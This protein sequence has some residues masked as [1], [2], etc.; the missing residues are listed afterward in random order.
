MKRHLKI[1]LVLLVVLLLVHVA[2]FFAQGTPGH[3]NIDEGIYQLQ[4]EAVAAG[5]GHAIDNGYEIFP[6]PE[7]Q[8]GNQRHTFVQDYGGRLVGQYPA[9]YG[10]LIAPLYGLLGFRA[11]VL[12]N[13]LAFPILVLLTWHIGSL[14]FDH[15]TAGWASLLLVGGTYTWGYALA[16]WPHVL[17]A[18]LQLLSV[19]LCIHAT[20]AE[21]RRDSILLALSGGLA[22]GLAMGVRYDALF[23][24]VPSLIV[25]T[26]RGR[27]RLVTAVS[28]TLGMLPVL[29]I[30]SAVNHAKYGVL[31]PFAYGSSTQPASVERRLLPYLAVY[32]IWWALEF[33]PMSIWSRRAIFIGGVS[34]LTLLGTA[35]L[36]V[37]DARMQLLQTTRGL[38][39]LGVDFRF[40]DTSF[41][42]L[43][44]QPIP[45]A[46]VAAGLGIKKALI[47]S[48]PWL[49]VVLACIPAALRSNPK[50][51]ALRLI[52]LFPPSLILFLAVN[53][54]HG[55]MCFNQRYLL[56]TLP[57]LALLGAYAAQQLLESWP[58]WTA[59]FGVLVVSITVALA[60]YAWWAPTPQKLLVEYLLAVL[61]A[62]A[63]SLA[64]GFTVVC[65][66][67][68]R[69]S[70]WRRTAVT[71]L[72]VGVALGG[73]FGLGFDM[74]NEW[75]LRSM[76]QRTAEQVAMNTRSTGLVVG[77]SAPDPL[78]G[79][80]DSTDLHLANPWLDDFT[81][82]HDLIDAH[83]VKGIPVY[84]AVFEQDY[85]APAVQDILARYGH[86]L[87]FEDYIDLYELSEL[88]L[89][90]TDSLDVDHNSL[91]RR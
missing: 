68:C 40:L 88:P 75:I 72:A 19:L 55:G 63:V 70:S 71:L 36:A 81:D 65:S 44:I 84:L 32:G 30:L 54:W 7:L 5:R 13:A 37:P 9:V 79:T 17:T 69:G 14:L 12:A 78:F 49:P 28:F 47:Q 66:R 61:V 77:P 2:L 10:Y 8:V 29:A 6:S 58:R 21:R 25:L 24:T 60:A 76:N 89:E 50:G 22:L 27:H 48:L 16:A 31:S 11:L 51:D 39:T 38:L 34:S 41:V 86:E 83:F 46:W 26:T 1:I 15:K 82:V 91:R 64:L 53:S 80:I 42:T 62:P 74:R 33:L 35:A 73:G 85:E 3:F 20:R 59:P 56:S 45:M 90:S 67:W 43:G 87:L 4:V 23:F 18:S 57:F 52:A